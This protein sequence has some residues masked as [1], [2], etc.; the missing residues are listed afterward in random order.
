[1]PQGIERLPGPAAV[2]MWDK[3]K[4]AALLRGAL[5]LGMPPSECWAKATGLIDSRKIMG[6]R[7]VVRPR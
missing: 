3:K 5:A 1:M 6:T 4:D 2:A 7:F